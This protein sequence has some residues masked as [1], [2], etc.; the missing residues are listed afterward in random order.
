MKFV[1]IMLK[2]IRTL[3]LSL[4]YLK[5]IILFERYLLLHTICDQNR[6]INIVKINFIKLNVYARINIRDDGE[7]A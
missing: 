6:V 1:K 5:T 3:S 4:H 7:N 2:W